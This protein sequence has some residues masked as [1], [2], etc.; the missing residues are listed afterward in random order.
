MHLAHCTLHDV[1]YTPF[2]PMK[3]G[4]VTNWILVVATLVTLGIAVQQRHR[5]ALKL[6]D[7]LGGHI[8]D[9]D[10]W[11]IMVPQ[12]VHDRADYVDDLFPLPPLSL[13]FLAPLTVL[14]RPNAQFIWVCLKLP[15]ACLAFALSTRLVTRAGQRLTGSA[16]ALILACW[17]LPIVLDMQQGQ[18]NFL[19]L[20]PLVAALAIAQND[21][22]VSDAAAGGLIGLAVA[23]KVTPLIFAGYFFWKRRWIVTA[24]AASSLLVW[25]LVIPGLAFGWDQNSRWLG[26]WAQ[27]MIVPYVTRGEVL[28]R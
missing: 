24:A 26:Q 27:I 21:T 20:V 2:P 15:L 18:M 6:Q 25:L 23:I 4:R 16:I 22:P 7:P 9:F 5:V 10:R 12:F 19:V 28:V 8:N 13:L 3:P 17:W 14:S 11:M 1:R